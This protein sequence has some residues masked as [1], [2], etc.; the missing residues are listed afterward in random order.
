MR[1]LFKKHDLWTC[2]TFFGEDEQFSL[3][4]GSHK[5]DDNNVYFKKLIYSPLDMPSGLLR[6]FV[7]MGMH[8]GGKDA[9]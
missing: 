7:F 8:R 9:D 6:G 5:S 2:A 1:P 3:D 4:F